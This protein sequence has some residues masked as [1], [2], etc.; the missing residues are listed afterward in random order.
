[1]HA[2][3]GFNLERRLDSIYPSDTNPSR[4]VLYGRHVFQYS[5]S[6]YQP[7][8]H[9]AEL[10]GGIQ[11][12]FPPF[13]RHSIPHG[14]P[15]RRTRTGGLHYHINYLTPY[16]DAEGGFQFD[17]TWQ[18]GAAVLQHETSFLNEGTAQLSFVKYV[19]DAS[20]WF[21]RVPPLERFL[22][23][24]GDTRLAFRVMGAGGLPD[25]GEYFALGGSQLFRGF[26]LRERQGSAIRGGS[27]G[28]RCAVG[29]GP[30]LG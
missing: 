4:A 25:R 10:F 21:E 23:W 5:S 18:T 29:R 15:L 19:P 6:L 14:I 27:V 28:W 20:G 13:I 7:P 3:I 8:M 16:W 1:P 24:L 11:D 30:G 2:Q 9:Y 26:D 12:N 22:H 17:A